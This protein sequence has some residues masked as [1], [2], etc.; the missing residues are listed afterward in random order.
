MIGYECGIKPR[1]AVLGDMTFS[2][3]LMEAGFLGIAYL[4]IPKNI[5]EGNLVEVALLF[6]KKR[7]GKKAFLN[8][9]HWVEGSNNDGDAVE[10]EFVESAKGGY[11][12]CIYPNPELLMERCLPKSLLNWVLPLTGFA[13]HFKLIDNVSPQ[14]KEFK[15]AMKFCQLKIIAIDKEGSL[16]LP[17]KFILKKKINFYQEGNIPEKT[18]TKSFF[19]KS[20]PNGVYEEEPPSLLELNVDIENNRLE[21]IK[22]FLP[23]TYEKIRQN[24]HL[25]V[26]IEDLKEEYSLSQVIQAICNLVLLERLQ[27]E[28]L[29]HIIRNQEDFHM[30]ILTYLDENPEEFNSYFPAFDQISKE[31]IKQ[32]IQLD[33]KDYE[34]FKE[35]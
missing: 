27:F 18:H 25:Q 29:E 22:N 8:I 2:N 7:L 24:G 28:N 17:D 31:K 13:T 19:D 20:N 16:L 11:T 34:S 6:E 9:L 30:N 21:K 23:L 33:I 4:K 15:K 26:L 3:E 32:Q 14:Y 35:E 1:V 5:L 12:L 10:L